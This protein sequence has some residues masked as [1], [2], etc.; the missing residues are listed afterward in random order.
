MKRCSENPYDD[1]LSKEL[2][3]KKVAVAS[4][5]ATIVQLVRTFW[6]DM[7]P[8]EF[9]V[10]EP[11]EPSEDMLSCDEFEKKLNASHWANIYDQSE[12]LLEMVKL[13]ERISIRTRMLSFRFGQPEFQ[14]MKQVM[15]I[16]LAGT[17]GIFHS[18]VELSDMDEK[19]ITGLHSS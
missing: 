12:F 4:Q 7:V 18:M 2:Q 8:R 16:I 17:R 15:Q 3:L 10:Q 5:R 14:E 11:N 13:S 1:A 6:I 9:A 19:K